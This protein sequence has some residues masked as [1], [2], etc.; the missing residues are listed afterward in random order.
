MALELKYCVA[1]F[2]NG[3]QFYAGNVVSYG[4]TLPTFVDDADDMVTYD[5][6]D[7]ALTA[8]EYIMRVYP[9]AP[10]HVARYV[11]DDGQG[12]I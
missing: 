7:D 3:V 9:S 8:A 12:V 11:A 6:I 1:M 2:D 4:M 5:D 10:V